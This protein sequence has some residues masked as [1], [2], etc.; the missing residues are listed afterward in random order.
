MSNILNF[1]RAIKQEAYKVVWPSK[2]ETTQGALTIIMMSVISALFF[3]LIDQ[4]FRF[5]LAYLIG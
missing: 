1:F 5:A 3:L 2:K 4:L